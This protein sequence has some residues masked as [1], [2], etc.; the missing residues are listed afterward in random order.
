MGSCL[1]VSH[2]TLSNY[3]IGVILNTASYTTG[4]QAISV[5]GEAVAVVPAAPAEENQAQNHNASSD[6]Q[7]AAPSVLKIAG[8]I[9]MPN[10]A[11]MAVA[12]SSLVARGKDNRFGRAGLL[13]T[14]WCTPC[15]NIQPSVTP[16]VG[17]RC[18]KRI[19]HWKFY[20]FCCHW[21]YCVSQQFC[22]HC[23]WGCN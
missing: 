8:H 9:V 17:V 22:S 2:S 7:E 4:G 16:A 18:W 1:P 19:V 14:F 5:P 15:G 20:R 6:N 10:P 11:G 21:R 12:G 23:R 13:G 3:S